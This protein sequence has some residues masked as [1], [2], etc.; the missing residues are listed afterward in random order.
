MAP[1]VGG[2][3]TTGGLNV[4]PGRAP[5]ANAQLAD[6]VSD[7][8]MLSLVETGPTKV[9]RAEACPQEPMEGPRQRKSPSM[10]SVTGIG[11]M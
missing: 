8:A 2:G 1:M 4:K 9:V 6:M 10:S 11:R 7:L 3:V 5:A